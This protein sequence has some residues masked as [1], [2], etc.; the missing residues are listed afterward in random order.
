MTNTLFQDPAIVNGS[1]YR[2]NLTGVLR[3]P[4][5]SSAEM[6]QARKMRLPGEKRVRAPRV[7]WYPT[8]EFIER[9][10]FFAQDEETALKILSAGKQE[11]A[12]EKPKPEFV[13]ATIDIGNSDD[14]LTQHKWASYIRN[15]NNIINELVAEVHFV[16]GTSIE[17]AYQSY[18]WVATIRPDTVPTL[19]ERLNNVRNAYNQ[20]SIAMTIGET[21][22]I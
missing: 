10:T 3:T 17:S 15:T 21:Q 14:K 6:L 5:S 13:T 19:R 2:D 7:H 22:F 20:D 1:V 4:V 9:H 16:G 12:E 8:A 18:C 11:P